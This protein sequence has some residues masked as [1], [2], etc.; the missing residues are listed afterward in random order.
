MVFYNRLD[1]ILLDV[2][3]GFH[4]L[5]LVLQDAESSKRKQ[6]KRMEE[7]AAYASACCRCRRLSERKRSWA[8]ERRSHTHRNRVKIIVRFGIEG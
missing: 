2:R 1:D 5:H 4:G 3:G 6:T 8:K 7:S